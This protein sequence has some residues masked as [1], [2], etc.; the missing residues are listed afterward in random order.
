MAAVS[1]GEEADQ[2]LA[3]VNTVV[4]MQ[5]SS[6]RVMDE[7]EQA[8]VLRALER[9]YGCGPRA[10][11]QLPAPQPVSFDRGGLAHLRPRAG[12]YLCTLKADGVRFVL[13]LMM[14]KDEPVAVMV[15]RLL[16]MYE[17]PV[18]A[19]LRHFCAEGAET[20]AGTVVDG[21]LV[22]CEDGMHF[23]AFDAVVI[24]GRSVA[25]EPLPERMAHIHNGFHLMEDEARRRHAPS[26]TAAD[27][28]QIANEQGK[29]VMLAEGTP[30]LLQAKRWWSMRDLG[31]MWATQTDLG[32]P[33]DG[34]VLQ[35]R[36]HPVT[37][38]TDRAMYKWKSMHSVDVLLRS[39][40]DEPCVGVAGE[41]VPASEALRAH[42]ERGGVRRSKRRR[43]PE[44]PEAVESIVLRD[45]QLLRMLAANQA[46]TDS[47]VE[48]SV[49]LEGACLVLT[50]TRERPDK[51]DPNDITTVL[52]AAE[53]MR[54]L[55]T[56]EMLEGLA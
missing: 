15:D 39:G 2:V 33:V 29:I 1:L 13:V 11:R 20:G 10:G 27:A 48:C 46:P 44:G 56:V 30:M 28:E 17:V 43:T 16:A 38:G 22:A 34:I 50:P 35:R 37:S 36:D 21:E 49:R 54:D 25:H 9:A 4:S 18:V 24:R 51:A 55:V 8:L 6:S 23:L 52:K 7:E 14:F 41:A 47:V 26:V 45:N 19:Q 5:P 32:V 42:A 31:T 53:A 3:I 12:E 40:C